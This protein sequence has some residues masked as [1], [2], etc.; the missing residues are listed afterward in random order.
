[1]DKNS[2]GF[3]HIFLALLIAIVGIL[4]VGYY[5]YKNGQIKIPSQNISVNSPTPTSAPTELNDWKTFNSKMYNFSIKYP[6]DWV[7]SRTGN[8]DPSESDQQIFSSKCDYEAENL[9]S[10]IVI[11]ES[12]LESNQNLDN[13]F[14]DQ[15]ILRPFDLFTNVTN[16]KLDEGK[17]YL[18]DWF[19]ANE[20]SVNSTKYGY[21]I[22]HRAMISDRNGV[23]L[24]FV[25]T[26]TQK[27]HKMTNPSDWQ[28]KQ[29]FDQI[30]ST[31]RFLT[32]GIT[33]ADSGYY[34]DI[35]NVKFKAGTNISNTTSL[36]PENLMNNVSRIYPHTES[37]TD[38]SVMKY[39]FRIN[40]K[41]GTDGSEFLDKLTKLSNVEIAE[42]APK[43]QP[44][45]QP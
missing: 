40:L 42:K 29:I 6:P 26:E 2:R 11:E 23:R 25:Y 14:D 3:I 16:I 27:D 28:N 15:K 22:L 41:P 33:E 24:L 38:N 7:V 9:C 10:Q 8:E 32:K 35:I 1:M 36:L 18:Y 17:A 30:I 5:A 31:F 21:G 39:W 43:P 12:S 45:P 34:D 19:S 44:P 13:Y 37:L 4:I 20:G